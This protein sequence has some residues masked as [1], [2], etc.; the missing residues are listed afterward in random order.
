MIGPLIYGI[1]KFMKFK[2]SIM[3]TAQLMKMMEYPSII[4]KPYQ[5]NVPG[6]EPGHAIET[7]SE[8]I[9]AGAVSSA[10]GR[11]INFLIIN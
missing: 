3:R 6:E 7:F 4:L 10:N 8:E 1:L 5:F 9:G 2:T 11:P